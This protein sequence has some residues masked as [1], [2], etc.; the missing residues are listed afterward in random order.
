MSFL[1]ALGEGAIIIGLLALWC[2]V[3]RFIH[4]RRG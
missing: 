1:T 3:D 4:Q 2:L